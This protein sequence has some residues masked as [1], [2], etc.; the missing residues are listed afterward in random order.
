M[1]YRAMND[2][3]KKYPGFAGNAYVDAKGTGMSTGRWTFDNT[4]SEWHNAGFGVFRDTLTI[5]QKY[6]RENEARLL[7]K[8]VVLPEPAARRERAKKDAATLKKLQSK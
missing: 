3:T 4:A 6:H 8:N 7:K 5:L 2:E 1:G